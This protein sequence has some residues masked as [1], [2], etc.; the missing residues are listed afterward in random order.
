MLQV[1]KNMGYNQN[2]QQAQQQEQNSK[3]YNM[4]Q[5]Q[6]AVNAMNAIAHRKGSLPSNIHQNL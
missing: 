4:R 1:M 2:Q 3:Y 5:Q 6:M